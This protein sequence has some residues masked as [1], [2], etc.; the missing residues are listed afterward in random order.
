M[1][2]PASI[3][4]V[5]FALAFTSGYGTQA[6]AQSHNEAACGLEQ[7]LGPWRATCHEPQHITASV[8]AVAE[9]TE[10]RMARVATFSV[11]GRSRFPSDRDNGAVWA[12][13]GLSLQMAVGIG[14]RLGPLR[15]GIFPTIHWSQNRDFVVADTAV[16]PHSSYLYPWL[17]APSIDWPQRMGGAAAGDLSLGQTFVEVTGWSRAALGISTENIWWGPSQR[18][19]MLLGATS[20]GFPH[21]Y[22]RSPTVAFGPVQAIVRA[23]SGRLTESQYFD[24]SEDNDHNLLSAIR[25]EIGLNSLLPGAQ[26][27]LTSMVRQQLGTELSFRDVLGL[28][29]PRSTTQSR[30]GDKAADG[31][32]AATLVLPIKSLGVR[33]HGTWGRGDFFVDAED[34]LTEPDHNQFWSVGF[35]QEWRRSDGG[36]TWAL[37]AEHASSAA[38]PPQFGVRR[39]GFSVGLYRHSGTTQGHTHRGQLLGASIGPGARATYFSL[40]RT[41]AG[42][43]VGVLVERVLWDIDGYSLDL[44]SGFPNGQDREWLFGGRLGTDLNIPGIE[45]LRADAF[46]GVSIRRNRQYVRFTGDLLN[47]PEREINFWLDL[48]IAWTPDRGDAPQ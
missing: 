20:E 7:R 12:G 43:L 17:A 15:Y 30:P 27:A 34:L 42:Q 14:G 1:R 44:R 35:D 45:H 40:D 28:L 5:W 31:I 18:Y 25:L 24:Q 19:P 16:A 33:L 36:A 9:G 37:S 41:H 48:R 22:G 8:P 4:T 13:K 11:F 3:V 26:V 6:V 46:G 38:T 23:V 47:Y 2:F 29:L 10:K 39:E 32:G 21:V